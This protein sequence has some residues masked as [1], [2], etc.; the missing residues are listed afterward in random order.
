MKHLIKY[1]LF[2]LAGTA[3]YFVF[4]FVSQVADWRVALLASGSLVGTYIG[5]AFAQIPPSQRQRA[6]YVAR[7][8]C[9]IEAAYGFLYVLSLQSPEAFQRP[10]SLWISAPLAL[11][12]GASFSILAYLVSLFV[13]HER[14]DVAQDGALSIQDQ[15]DMAIVETLDQIAAHLAPPTAPQLTDERISMRQAARQAGVPLTTYR[16]RAKIQKET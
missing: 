10:L 3:A 2:S 5:L 13:V 11:L 9:G 4:E 14:G 8:A 1:A 6:V 15:R 7:A 12:H 16:R